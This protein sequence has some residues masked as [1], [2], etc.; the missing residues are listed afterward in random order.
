LTVE[1]YTKIVPNYIFMYYY[2]KSNIYENK[3]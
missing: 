1:G 3:P 2:L